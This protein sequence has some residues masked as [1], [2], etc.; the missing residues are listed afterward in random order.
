LRADVAACLEQGFTEI[1]IFPD[2]RATGGDLTVAVE[3]TA[4]E[5][6]TLRSQ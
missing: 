4:Q 1:I 6:A 2:V 3:A 5:L